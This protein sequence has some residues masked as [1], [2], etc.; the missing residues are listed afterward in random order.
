VV[1]PVVLDMVKT[2][3]I[4]ETLRLAGVARVEQ[5]DLPFPA[6]HQDRYVKKLMAHARTWRRRRI[7]LPL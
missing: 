1:A 2:G 6:R 7:L 4:A 5:V 3:D